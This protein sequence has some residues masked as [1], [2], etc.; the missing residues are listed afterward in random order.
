MS[1][2][3][4]KNNFAT[5]AT[6]AKNMDNNID[7]F[8]IQLASHLESVFGFTIKEN[9]I[10]RFKDDVVLK[11]F[12]SF[13]THS[14]KVKKNKLEEEDKPKKRTTGFILFNMKKREELILQSHEAT[15]E[16][17]GKMVGNAW[18]KLS[19]TEKETY[20]REAA[21]QN[22][23]EYKE[24]VVKEKTVL[25]NCSYEGCVRRCKGEAIDGIFLCSEHKKRDKKQKKEI[26][27]LRG[28]SRS[29]DEQSSSRS[30]SDSESKNKEE[31]PVVSGGKKVKTEKQSKV[32]EVVSEVIDKKSS[33]KI[34]ESDS[35]EEDI[36]KS[37][38]LSHCSFKFNKEKPVKLSDGD[39]WQ[40]RGIK[41]SEKLIHLKTNLVVNVNNKRVYLV[42]LS[43]NENV[44]E[45]YDLPNVILKWCDESGIVVDEETPQL[46]ELEM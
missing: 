21:L 12:G 22:G 35:E 16:E 24:K 2:N 7:A 32:E 1:F 4:F 40:F 42:G 9:D 13:E 39:F 30:H 15:F 41:G 46:D 33:K 29:L 26:L 11:S 38:I 37:K 3:F 20:N 5:I 36:P 31:N 43:I 23:V 45:K 6:I 25:P 19:E 44:Y 8:C 18:K 14:V 27:T 10:Q 17:I 34:V 28:D